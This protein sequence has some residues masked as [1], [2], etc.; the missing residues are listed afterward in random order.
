MEWHHFQ[1]YC[2]WVM[3]VDVVPKERRSTPM[4][5]TSGH[6]QNSGSIANEFSLNPWYSTLRFPPTW[7]PEGYN[8]WHKVWDWWYDSHSEN[9]AI[10]EEQTMV[11][12]G[13]HTC[14]LL[15]KTIIRWRLCEKI[16][17][18]IKLSLFGMCNFHDLG[19]NIYWEKN[20]GH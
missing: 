14:P 17:Y 11:P 6:W 3:L 8:L 13:I 19:I 16:G 12:T 9:L 10:W 1:T 2:E 5:P 15:V 4:L 7:I 20:Q 18:G